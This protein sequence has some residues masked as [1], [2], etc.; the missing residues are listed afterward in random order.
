MK[1]RTDCSD[2]CNF[3]DNTAFLFLSQRSKVLD[4]KTGI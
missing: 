4:K 1:K 3:V 2:F